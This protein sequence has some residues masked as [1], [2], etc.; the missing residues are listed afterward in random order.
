[1]TRIRLCR[2]D[3]DV[4]DVLVDR[5]LDG[6][7][8]P[9]AHVNALRQRRRVFPGGGEEVS[10]NDKGRCRQKGEMERERGEGDQ[11]LLRGKERRGDLSA[12]VAG[13]LQ[14]KKEVSGAG[15]GRKRRTGWNEMGTNAVGKASARDER[16]LELLSCSSKLCRIVSHPAR[17]GGV[18]M[19]PRTEEQG[20]K[21]RHR[22]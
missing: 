22:A 7:H 20:S 12:A 21:G 1:M 2:S 13:K 5:G 15:Q 14:K 19:S 4:L 17:G 16:D 10:V 3:N 11:R 6:A 8:E 9:G 18:S